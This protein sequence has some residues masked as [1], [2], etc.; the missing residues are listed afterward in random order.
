MDQVH[1]RPTAMI[2]NLVTAAATI[3][4]AGVRAT[5]AH[6]SQSAHHAFLLEWSGGGPMASL[7]L[8]PFCHFRGQPVRSPLRPVA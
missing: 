2:E 7:V 5:A 1:A 3:P 6:G 8:P 4:D